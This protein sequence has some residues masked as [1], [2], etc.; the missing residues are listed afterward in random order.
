M[1]NRAEAVLADVTASASWYRYVLVFFARELWRSL[2]GP[3]YVKIALIIVC[4][5]I[6][7]PGDEIALIALTVWA[8]RRRAREMTDE[9]REAIGG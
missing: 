8:R 6:P 7:G 1:R 9:M 2:P 3:W 5:L 4:Q